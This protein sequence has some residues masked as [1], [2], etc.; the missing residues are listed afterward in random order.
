VISPGSSRQLEIPLRVT[1]NAGLF[2]IS[3]RITW[4]DREQA[5]KELLFHEQVR[6]IPAPSHFKPI[7]NPYSTGRPLIPGSPVFVGRQ[8]IFDFVKKSISGGHLVVLVG[9]RRMGK[10]S[11]LRQLS[12]RMGDDWVVAYLDG[13]GLGLTGG[14]ENWLADIALEISRVAGLH[15]SP[16]PTELGSQPGSLFEAFLQQVGLGIDQGRRLLLLFDEFEEIE[17]R[18]RLGEL[19]PSIFP[20]LRHLL[21]FGEAGFLLAGTKRLERLSPEYWTP[22]FNISLYREIPPL[23]DASARKLIHAPVEDRLLY[24]DLAVDKLLRLSGRQPYFLQLLCYALVSYCN[25]EHISYV[26]TAEVGAA[27]EDA[28]MLGQAHLHFLWKGAS[29]EGQVVLSALAWL[30]SSGELGTVEAIAARLRSLDRRQEIGILPETLLQ[31]I[32][33][34]LLN[35]TTDHRYQFNADLM[36]SWIMRRKII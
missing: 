20:Y 30:L 15:S 34:D 17:S 31:L 18:V 13:Q 26:T 33:L 25:R 22:L 7:P 14:L 35:E 8:D 32:N 36:I 9:E 4:D 24:D 1:G 11:I 19:T 23:D 2:E 6:L 10:S 12:T 16:S 21:Q 5:Q 3:I 27:E 29:L 28:L